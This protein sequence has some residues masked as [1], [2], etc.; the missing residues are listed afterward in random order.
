MNHE[1]S[2]FW[3]CLNFIFRYNHFEQLEVHKLKTKQNKKPLS[4]YSQPCFPGEIISWGIG[5][6]LFPSLW[7]GQPYMCANIAHIDVHYFHVILFCY[8]FFFFIYMRIQCLGHFSPLPPPPP[9]LFFNGCSL[10]NLSTL[11]S[12]KKMT[13]LSWQEVECLPCKCEALSSNP[14]TTKKDYSLARRSVT[15][16]CWTGSLPLYIYRRAELM[17]QFVHSLWT[18]A[19]FY[20]LPTSVLARSTSLSTVTVKLLWGFYSMLSFYVTD[21]RVFLSEKLGTQILH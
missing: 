19:D 2:P 20:N 21:Y 6:G 17:K 11:S 8:L 5:F 15:P 1:L 13:I 14:S 7:N 16:C 9:Y 10:S 18:L 4:L 3:N 12:F